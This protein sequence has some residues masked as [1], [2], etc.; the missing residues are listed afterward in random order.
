MAATLVLASCSSTSF[1]YNRL[2]L[3]VP[4]YLGS[5][6]DFNPE[7]RQLLD[8]LLADYLQRHRRDE[9]PRYIA[10]LD[11]ATALLDRQRISPQDLADLYQQAEQAGNRLQ[12]DTL[13][14][15]LALGAELDKQQVQD[16]L[17][18]LQARQQ[19]YEDE[20]LGR[21]DREYREEAYDSLHNNSRKYLG[22]L[23]PPQRE[24]LR[25]ASTQLKRA[26]ATWLAAR[27]AWLDALAEL[28]QREPGWQQRVRIAFGQR[29]AHFARD[30][31]VLYD[32]NLAVTQRALA[33]V[34]T[35][36]NERQEQHL[37]RELG[38]L[39]SQ[40]QRLVADD[41]HFSGA[42]PGDPGSGPAPLGR[43]SGRHTLT[44]DPVSA[45]ALCPVQAGVGLFHQGLDTTGFPGVGNPSADGQTDVIHIQA[46]IQGGNPAADA[47][48]RR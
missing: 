24:E 27:Q 2:H 38:K 14:W 3:L 22:R 48:Q 5:Y 40:L 6:V 11:D 44:D 21:D 39:R 17:R 36:R 26:D 10:I 15:L 41:R 35:S 8:Q 47:L 33:N 4:W 7:Q 43:L 31:R 23:S 25:H 32:H 13:E 29:E 12:T 30:Y 28:L 45:T 18:E 19:E 46:Q 37:R 34:L 1:F 9:L 16:F 42:R 20:Y